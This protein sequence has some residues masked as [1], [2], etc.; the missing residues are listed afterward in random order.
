MGNQNQGIDSNNNNQISN[1]PTS[2]NTQSIYQNP[3]SNPNPYPNPY[4]NINQNQGK[5]P[6]INMHIN[7]VATNYLKNLTG[8]QIQNPMKP[9]MMQPKKQYKYTITKS[10]LIEVYK[11]F[12]IKG[13]EEY[14]NK[15]LFNEALSVLFNFPNSPIIHHTY[16]SERLYSLLDDSKDEKIQIDEYLN[17]ISNVLSNKVYRDRRINI[18]T[19]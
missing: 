9:Q 14:L 2:Q 17:G 15:T 16:L 6:M 7:K 19:F 3:N 13:R 12:S 8:Q 10:R 11:Q 4:P 5:N 18:L 1:N